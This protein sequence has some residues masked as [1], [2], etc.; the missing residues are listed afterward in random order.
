VDG[1]PVR[2]TAVVAAVH[3]AAA[4]VAVAAA[5]GETAI[6]TRRSDRH[7]PPSARV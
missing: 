4:A 1:L 5:A 2:R 6:R 7:A 3:M